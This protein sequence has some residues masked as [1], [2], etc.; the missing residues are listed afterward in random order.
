MGSISPSD[1]CAPREVRVP[2]KLAARGKKLSFKRMG[3][4]GKETWFSPRQHRTRKGTEVG[5]GE[6]V[7]LAF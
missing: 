7:G 2:R 4:I 5:A 6:N 3:L 1:T